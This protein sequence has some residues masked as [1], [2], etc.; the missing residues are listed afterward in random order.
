MDMT[1]NAYG[2]PQMRASDADRDAALADLSEHFQAGRL[3]SDEL[4]ERT[5][6]ALAART[7]GELRDLMGDLPAARPA[8]PLPLPI[9]GG[10]RELVPTLVIVL[11][12]LA[13]AATVFG[14]VL[15]SAGG[16][17]WLVTPIAL[18]VARRVRIGR[19]PRSQFTRRG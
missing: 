1:A 7:V 19:L 13:L 11:I 5:S 10:R 12:G 6:R 8:A 9:P 16:T 14:S 3:T 2:T 15:T 4:D 18:I 17:A